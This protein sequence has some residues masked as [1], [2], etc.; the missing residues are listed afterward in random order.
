[1]KQIVPEVVEAAHKVGDSEVLSS[2]KLGAAQGPH[3]PSPLPTSQQGEDMPVK[4]IQ[5]TLDGASE[6]KVFLED[7]LPSVGGYTPLFIREEPRD[8]SPDNDLTPTSKGS[9]TKSSTS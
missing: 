7:P 4:I 9:S 1:M 5:D 8:K 3:G 2:Q 6:G